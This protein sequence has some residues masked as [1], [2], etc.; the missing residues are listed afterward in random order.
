MQISCLFLFLSF[1]FPFLPSVLP[2]VVLEIIPKILA[3]A[4]KYCATELYPRPFK[5]FELGMVVQACKPSY[6]SVYHGAR[7]VKVKI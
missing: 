5:K 3:H 2:F 6:L 1:L 4:R 7:P